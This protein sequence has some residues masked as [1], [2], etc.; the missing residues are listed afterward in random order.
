MQGRVSKSL[1]RESSPART[2]GRSP[3]VLTRTWGKHLHLPRGCFRLASNGEGRAPTLIEVGRMRSESDKTNTRMKTRRGVVRRA[4]SEGTR[5]S[6]SWGEDSFLS[7]NKSR[8]EPAP[9]TA[10]WRGTGGTKEQGVRSPSGNSPRRMPSGAPAL[11]A[12]APQT[13]RP[14][15]EYLVFL[16]EPLSAHSPSSRAKLATGHAFKKVLS[17]PTLKV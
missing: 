14:S 7:P 11:G 6:P 3:C 4:D 8:P 13:I 15:T 10:Q 2:G 12:D 17:P 9:S 5:R 1:K 16:A